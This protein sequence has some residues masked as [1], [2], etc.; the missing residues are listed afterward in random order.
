[1]PA[2]LADIRRFL[3][4]TFNDDE[5]TTLCFDHFPEVFQ[6]FA[7]GMTLGRKAL[8]LVDYCRRRE[9]VAELLDI[10]RRERPESFG[11]AL[12]GRIRAVERR[13]NINTAGVE[14]L[15]NLPGIGEKLAGGIV[16]GRPF[17]VVDDLARVLGIGPKRLAAVQDW[18][19]V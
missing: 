2:S 17:E 16:A 4:D 18:C 7:A 15:R 5:L 9:R 1:M 6:E 11:K 3:I 10:L 13:V 14:E 12:S 19:V 8:Q